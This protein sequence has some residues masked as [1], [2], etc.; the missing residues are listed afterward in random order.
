MSAAAAAVPAATATAM[1]HASAP[2][3]STASHGAVESTASVDRPMKSATRGCTSG[4]ALMHTRVSRKA[5]PVEGA[6][7]IG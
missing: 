3:K 5:G 2:M 1:A 6:K 4:E 7:R